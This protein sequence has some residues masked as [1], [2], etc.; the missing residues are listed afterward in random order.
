MKVLSWIIAIVGLWEFGDITA[1]FVP[2]FGKIPDVLW[3]HIIVGLILMIAGIWA[4]RTSNVGTAKTMNWI[5]AGAGLWLMISSFILRYP[6]INAGL[7]NDL[8]VGVIAFV[9]GVWAALTS[10]RVTG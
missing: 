10:P 3:N 6:I 9:L 5:A 7:W 1:L 2:D 8:I 4:A